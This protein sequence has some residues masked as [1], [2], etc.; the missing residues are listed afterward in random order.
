MGS[1]SGVYRNERGK[2]KQGEVGA[3]GELGR[4]VSCLPPSKDRE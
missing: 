3:C 1:R 2:G 4:F